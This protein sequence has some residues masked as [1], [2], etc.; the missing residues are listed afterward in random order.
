[1]VFNSK[2]I[3]MSRASLVTM[4]F[5]KHGAEDSNPHSSDIHTCLK[6]CVLEALWNYLL[7]IRYDQLT[8]PEIMFFL[9]VILN[10]VSL[11]TTPYILRT[12]SNG[13]TIDLN[14]EV[15]QFNSSR[16]VADMITFN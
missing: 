14:T 3:G 11:S 10:K 2:H 15:I 1:V 13:Q 5:S 9:R 7:V 12:T 4:A 16:H 6:F 8:L